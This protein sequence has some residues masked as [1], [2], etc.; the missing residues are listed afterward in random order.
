[1]GNVFI[2]IPVFVEHKPI[3]IL[4]TVA[5]LSKAPSITQTNASNNN[6]MQV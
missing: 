2:R 1:M 5:H 4:Q 3:A 6:Q